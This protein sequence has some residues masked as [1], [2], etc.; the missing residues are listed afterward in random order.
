MAAQKLVNAEIDHKVAYFSLLALYEQ[1][2][3]QFDLGS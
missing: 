2:L 3:E 1:L